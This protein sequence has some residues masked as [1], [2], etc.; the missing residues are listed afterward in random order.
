RVPKTEFATQPTPEG[1]TR[2]IT[3]L[4]PLP[5]ADDW[6]TL[7][8]GTVAVVRVLDY[9]IDWYTPDGKH[10]S[11]AKLPFDWKQ[12]TDEDKSKMIDSLK[13]AADV[14]TKQMAALT[15]GTGNGSRIA[16]EPIAAEKLPDYYPPIRQG[17]TFADADGNLWILPATSSLSAT[18]MIASMTNAGRG[19]RGAGGFGG[20]NGGRGGRDQGGAAGGR[21]TGAAGGA[22]GAARGG[23]AAAAGTAGG[24]SGAGAANGRGALAGLDALLP[25][26]ST[27]SLNYD[28]IN[29]KGELVERVQL[30][31]GRTIVG[32]APKGVI[33]LSVRE[34]R[35]M[36]I[37]KYVRP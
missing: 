3:K 37:E 36:F 12:L 33:Y 10:A 24:A 4:N 5:Q 32:F 30:P 29:R 34:G 23:Q 25:P 1:G 2:V 8:D 13:A 6:A 26:P 9:H 20:D 35:S 31:P 21:G 7:S 19:G 22:A 16:F 18:D 11:S 28:V 27:I 17:S 14:Y 15:Q